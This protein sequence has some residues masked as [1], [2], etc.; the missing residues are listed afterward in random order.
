[1]TLMMVEIQEPDHYHVSSFPTSE[2]KYD[3]KVENGTITS[4]PCPDFTWDQTAY[5]YIFLSHRVETN[6]SIFEG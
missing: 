1:M 5:M 3:I 2:I 6:I 4:C